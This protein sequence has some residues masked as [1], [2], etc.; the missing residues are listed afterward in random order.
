MNALVVYLIIFVTQARGL[1]MMKVE[2]YP[3]LNGCRKALTERTV[4]MPGYGVSYYCSGDPHNPYMTPYDDRAARDQDPVPL[5][6]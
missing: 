3:S 6:H 2:E 1:G 4:H 5:I